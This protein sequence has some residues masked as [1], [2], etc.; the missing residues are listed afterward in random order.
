LLSTI[1]APLYKYIAGGLLFVCLLLGLRLGLEI[2]H[3]HKLETQLA[4]ATAQLNAIT[5]ARDTQKATTTE[6]IKVVTRTIHDADGRAKVI[7]QSPL[8]GECRTPS[9]VLRADL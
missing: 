4:K 1:F 2:R 8:P 3:A 7:E 5:T 9:A 6:R